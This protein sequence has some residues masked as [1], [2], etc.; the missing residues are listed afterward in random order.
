MIFNIRIDKDKARDTG[1]AISLVMML[2]EIWI[3]GGV[4]LKIALVSLVLSMTIPAIFRPAAYVWF[5]FS[6]L[7]GT[8]ISKIFLVMA[9]VLI[10]LPMGMIRK[11]MGKD[12]LQLKEW[13]KNNESSFQTRNHLFKNIDLEK[14]Y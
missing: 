10:V 1:L 4:Y 3:G 5:G 12:S 6:H 9:F 13:K 8:M 14:P 7:M 2:L 11:I